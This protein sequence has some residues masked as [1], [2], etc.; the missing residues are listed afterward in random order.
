MTLQTK[1]HSESGRSW[2]AMQLQI[3]N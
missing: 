2:S 3:F 1:L